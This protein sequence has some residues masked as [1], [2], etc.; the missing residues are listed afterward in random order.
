MCQAIEGLLSTLAVGTNRSCR[1]IHSFH[2]MTRE[3]SWAFLILFTFLSFVP[4]SGKRIAMHSICSTLAQ[5][6]RAAGRAGTGSQIHS[7]R[8]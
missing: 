7:G 8:R 6:A 2:Y 5:V 4:K 3:T 1:S